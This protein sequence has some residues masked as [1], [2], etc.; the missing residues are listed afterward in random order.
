MQLFLL[1][2]TAA[3]LTSCI[4]HVEQKAYDHNDL[5]SILRVCKGTTVVIAKGY[6]EGNFDAYKH[7]ILVKDTTGTTY[8]YI[9]ARYDVEVGDT[10]K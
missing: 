6:N 5:G 9:G 4:D 2:I 10:L 8:E 7:Y 3:L 1:V